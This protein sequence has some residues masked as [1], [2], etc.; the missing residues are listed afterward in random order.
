MRAF[1]FFMKRCPFYVDIT[2]M[3]AWQLAHTTFLAIQPWTEVE[4]K[5]R[6]NF[7]LRLLFPFFFAEHERKFPSKLLLSILNSKPT[8]PIVSRAQV[9]IRFFSLLC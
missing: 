2:D 9:N 4:V 8:L 6:F 3:T 5:K 1:K 7:C